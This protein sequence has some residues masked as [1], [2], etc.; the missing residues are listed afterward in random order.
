M[1]AAIHCWNLLCT[2]LWQWSISSTF[3]NATRCAKCRMVSVFINHERRLPRWK[4]QH[5][6]RLDFPSKTENPTRI[7]SGFSIEG[8]SNT[9]LV[10][11]FHQRRK[12][13]HESRLDFPSRENPTRILSGFS[14]G[15]K[16][17]YCTPFQHFAMQQVSW[18]PN[19]ASIHDCW[20][21]VGRW[22]I[23]PGTTR[24]LVVF[25]ALVVFSA[26]VAVFEMWIFS[27]YCN[28]TSVV[29]TK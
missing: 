23:Q 9:N 26:S 10:W 8:K 17:M 7:W 14:I 3:C 22:T 27:T 2:C 6:S 4:I 25:G 5:E 13:Q 16:C 11:I 20:V 12:I 19:G 15:V 29:V 28:A 1:G 24:Q 21:M 18:L